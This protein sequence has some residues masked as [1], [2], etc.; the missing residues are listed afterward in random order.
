[1]ASDSPL[2]APAP[3]PRRGIG[4][5]DIAA[6]LGLSPWCTPLQLWL[7]K[8]GRS[9]RTQ[10]ETAPIH[11]GV[12]LEDVIAREYANLQGVRVRRVPYT[13]RDPVE[14]WV[15]GNIDRVV[16]RGVP[17]W[18]GTGLRGVERILEIKTAGPHALHEWGPSGSADIPLHY[19]MQVIWYMGLT[20]VHQAEVVALL[21]GQDLRTYPIEF[22]RDL[23]EEI[24]ARA[25]EFWRLVETDTPPP[26]QTEQDAR[27]LYPRHQPDKVV[28]ADDALVELIDRLAM[29]QAERKV[30]EDEAQSIRAQ[31]LAAMGNAEAIMRQGKVL[32][33]WKNNRDGE[34]TDWQA[35]AMALRPEDETTWQQIVKRHTR[36]KP[37][38]RVF[39]LKVR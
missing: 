5:S 34:T 7:E 22:D 1:M 24:R 11:W 32:A 29:V 30:L 19:H 14:P 4:G 13:I 33:T 25:R 2:S 35:I 10:E 17:R 37:G 16:A 39:L 38:A 36:S 3:R 21:G 8:T 18:D 20:H 31:I 23:Y 15:I 6:I 28:E 9:E 27:L 26:P 12:V